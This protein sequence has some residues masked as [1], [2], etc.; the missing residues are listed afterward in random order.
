MQQYM[1]KYVNP[2]LTVHEQLYYKTHLGDEWDSLNGG[3][4]MMLRHYLFQF[5]NSF[6]ASSPYVLFAPKRCAAITGY[7]PSMSIRGGSSNNTTLKF[8]RERIGDIGMH[9]GMPEEYIERYGP[10][11]WLLIYMKIRFA[12]TSTNLNIKKDYNL[13]KIYK[14]Q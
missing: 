2:G 8:Y 11:F 9:G 13:K 12:E 6:V 5:Y 4:M 7:G 3:D 1:K 14:S 10:R